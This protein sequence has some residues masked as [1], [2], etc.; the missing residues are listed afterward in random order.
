MNPHPQIALFDLDG[1]LADYDGQLL[2]DLKKLHSYWEPEVEE[3]FNYMHMPSYLEARR[4]MITKQVGWWSKLNRLRLG[5]DILD[6]CKIIGFNIS[7]LTKGPS[8]KSHAWSE[9]IDWCNTHLKDYIDGVTITHNKGL[10]Y[11]R[12][13]VDDFPE[14]I[15]N[16]LEYRPRGLVIMPV[17]KRNIS[18]N[19]P[20]VIK[21]NGM[22][23]EE[24]DKKLLEAYNRD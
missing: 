19:H 17:N 13:L 4:Q 8:S 2:L 6:A 24:V 10:V 3:V 1:T 18:F 16:W 11:G 23:L 22:N 15:L 21:Y 7:I 20:N 12:V 14:Y 5:W 9:K